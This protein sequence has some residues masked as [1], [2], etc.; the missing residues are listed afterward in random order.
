MNSSFTVQ[1][2]RS[3]VTPTK[4]RGTRTSERSE[5]LSRVALSRAAGEE[6]SHGATTHAH[7]GYNNLDQRHGV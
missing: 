5:R 6:G 2:H 1:M 3:D 7:N 4:R